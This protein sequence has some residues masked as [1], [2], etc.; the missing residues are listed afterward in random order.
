MGSESK[1][2]AINALSDDER[3]VYDWLSERGSTLWAHH[4]I[5]SIEGRI[6]AAKWFAKEGEA[7]GSFVDARDLAALRKFNDD[8]AARAQAENKGFNTD[9]WDVT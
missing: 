1:I 9:R 2:Q 7:F 6:L 8:W 4:E 5:Q 3:L